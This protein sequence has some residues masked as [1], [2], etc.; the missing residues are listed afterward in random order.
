MFVGANATF[1]E[2][3]E[4]GTRQEGQVPHRND[5]DF[6]TVFQLRAK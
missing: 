1:S 2:E 5:W 4:R 3:A 6:G